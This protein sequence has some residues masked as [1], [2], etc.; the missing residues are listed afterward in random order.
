MSTGDRFGFVLSLFAL[1]A[2][3]IVVPGCGDTDL[4]GVAPEDAQQT[5][6][7]LNASAFPAHYARQW[8]VNM[9]NAVKFDGISPP[10]AARAYS[11]TAVAM[12]E[13]VVHGIPGARS[14]AGQLNGLGS[15]P[16]PAPSTQY[17][18]PTVLAQTMD[19]IVRADYPGS[20]YIFP[21]RVFF[22]FTTFTQSSLWLLGPTQIGYRRAA[23]VSETTIQNSIAYADQLADVLIPWILADG[24]LD[25][26]YKGFIPP[27]GPQYWVPTGFSD[28][29][30]VADPVEPHFG[31]VRPLVLTSSSECA[32]PPPPAFS[33]LPT[34]QMYLEAQQ[35]HQTE[36]NLTDEQREIA[37]YWADGPK[38]TST[39]AGHW[40]GI[41]TQFL[42]NRT[43]DEAVT[44]YAKTSLGYFDS[45]IAIWK[46]KYEHNLLRPETYIRRHIQ[47]DWRP[48]LPTPQ[49]PE[50][51]S[52]HS[53]QS[54]ASAVL[55]TSAFGN[56]SF[57]D[58]T[59][60]RRGFAARSFATF[61]DAAVEA[62]YSRLYGGIHYESGNTQ[63]RVLGSCV[64]NAI[65]SRVNFTL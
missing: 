43:L 63:G 33:T 40:V 42:R 34:S 41:A 4:G 58:N 39:P 9:Q 24:Y 14:L 44:G 65:L 23:G 35:V 60:I 50:Y 16:Q 55:F 13:A 37:R 36:S 1:S 59:K 47:A 3:A 38:D 52:G 26:R 8:M 64:G 18:W 62:S 31:D 49:F 19:R 48:F 28:T 6:A 22:E 11:Y 29:D 57:T 15:L 53:G 10:V 61:S 56:V 45:F 2:C 20:A 51:V 17:D 27:Q 25:L 21:P 32:P 46:S 5:S 30:K 7:S 12:Y 54:M